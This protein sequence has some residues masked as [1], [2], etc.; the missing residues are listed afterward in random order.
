MTED[1]LRDFSRADI[2]GDAAIPDNPHRSRGEA[3]Y[4]PILAILWAFCGFVHWS[5]WPRRRSCRRFPV[6]SSPQRPRHHV[7]QDARQVDC[8]RPRPGKPA[9]GETKPED[10]ETV[11]EAPPSKPTA[12][13]PKQKEVVA[14]ELDEDILEAAGKILDANLEKADKPDA[15][16][17][18]GSGEAIAALEEKNF[19]LRRRRSGLG[20]SSGAIQGSPRLSGRRGADFRTS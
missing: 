7:P 8:G 17:K 15:L 5:I 19:R 10:G 2:S 1:S 3:A 14:D 20:L 9:E 11:A 12:D 4:A 18:A 6:P 16:E 13:S